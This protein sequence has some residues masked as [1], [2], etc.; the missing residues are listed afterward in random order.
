M[1]DFVPYEVDVT[2]DDVKGGHGVKQGNI[3]A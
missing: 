2:L 3:Q 1:D